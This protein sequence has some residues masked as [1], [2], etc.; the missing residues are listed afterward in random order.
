M[1]PGLEP[2]QRRLVSETRAF[3]KEIEAHF[4]FLPNMKHF[5]Q[6]NMSANGRASFVDIST[7]QIVYG[8]YDNSGDGIIVLMD[9]NDKG[10]RY[11]REK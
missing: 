4:G 6:E 3:E 11:W 2:R 7:P 1:L 10:T 5:V 9:L 8:S